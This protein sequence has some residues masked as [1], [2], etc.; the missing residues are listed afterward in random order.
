MASNVQEFLDT[1]DKRYNETK[2]FYTNLLMER[3]IEGDNTTGLNLLLDN[4]AKMI[5]RR[6]Y[7]PDV[8]DLTFE[9][10]L[11]SD[12]EATVKAALKE[13]LG[14][15]EFRLTIAE[16]VTSAKI[17]FIDGLP[18]ERANKLIALAEKYF[19]NKEDT[20]LITND[21]PDYIFTD[22]RFD[23]E[24]YRAGFI[25]QLKDILDN[26]LQQKR[27][28]FE[29]LK[30]NKGVI[31]KVEPDY[32]NLDF[33][34]A[35]VT[36]TLADFMVKMDFLHD[37]NTYLLFATDI[38]ASMTS[39]MTGATSGRIKGD[40]ELKIPIHYN[41]G[42]LG[43]GLNRDGDGLEIRGRALYEGFTKRANAYTTRLESILSDGDYQITFE[44][45][46]DYGWYFGED[47]AKLAEETVAFELKQ[48][49]NLYC[50][51]NR[52]PAKLNNKD[53]LTI[54][55]NNADVTE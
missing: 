52:I 35:H 44:G 32:Y 41:A 54:T 33:S 40:Y 46:G 55:I 50:N 22:I 2:E 12:Y 42:R 29:T 25:E 23:F 19:A 48:L 8:D 3:Y 30:S 10:N 39:Y 11:E 31:I 51:K 1:I 5:I 20:I 28:K 16:R 36:R 21:A 13:E 34:R 43:Y 45:N 9:F 17:S 26:F 37:N 47:K 38:I 53:G 4:L 24:K 14:D 27:F 7:K 18:K 15:N 6:Q 49:I